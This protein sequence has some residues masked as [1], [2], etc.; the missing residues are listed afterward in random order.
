MDILI[1]GL[2]PNAPPSV[3]QLSKTLLQ[4]VEILSA[5]QN[6]QKDAEGKPISVGVVNLLLTPEQAEI[7]TLATD[8]KIQLSLR[9]PLDKEE[10][11]THGSA[12]TALFSGQQYKGPEPEHRPVVAER[13]VSVAPVAAPK[14]P[15]IVEIYQGGKK[16]EARFRPEENQ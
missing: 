11:K 13:K 2:P 9:N 14:P 4:N 16:D 6:I 7:I 3:G 1:E 10:V 5:G 15:V 12:T 8:M